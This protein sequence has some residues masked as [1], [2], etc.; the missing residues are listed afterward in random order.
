MHIYRGEF[1]KDIK[2]RE[3][4]LKTCKGFE[5]KKVSTYIQSSKGNFTVPFTT[6]YW[7]RERQ[8]I[9]VYRQI[10]LGIITAP[11]SGRCG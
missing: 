3:T 8:Y 1:M 5:I 7:H 10:Q 4:R 2:L 6:Y 9:I 11:P